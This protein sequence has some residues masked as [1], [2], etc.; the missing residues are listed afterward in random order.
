MEQ[1]PYDTDPKLSEYLTRHLRELFFDRGKATDIT[2]LTNRVAALE[3]RPRGGMRKTMPQVIG[4]LGAAFV[5]VVDYQLNCFGDNQYVL[6]DF[7]A[8]TL[9][10]ELAGNYT[11]QMNMEISLTSDNNSNRNFHIR[12]YDLTDSAPIVET[13]NL[14][15]IGAYQGGT[16]LSI[17]IPSSIISAVNKSY[18]M[19]VG[20][21]STFA[22][23][24]VHQASF[25][26]MAL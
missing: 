6:L 16:T 7:A 24:T 25:T 5:S 2:A 8:G 13:D 1:P 26:V 21:G 22:A 9:T 15:Y 4:A 19:Q 18:V 20:G 17:T 12:L 10:P 23:F 11:I 14:I 3:N